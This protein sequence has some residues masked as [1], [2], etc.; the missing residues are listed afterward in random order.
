MS[1]L[2][3]GTIGKICFFSRIPMIG[4]IGLSVQ[5]DCHFFGKACRLP[6]RSPL[7]IGRL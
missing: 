5:S 6:G 3:A 4:R 1:R 2:G 7:G